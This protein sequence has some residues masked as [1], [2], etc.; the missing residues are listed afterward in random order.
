MRKEEN[1][2][3][4]ENCAF[5]AYLPPTN[6]FSTILYFH[7]GGFESGDKAD[8][9]Q[10]ELAKSFARLG[11]GFISANYRMYPSGARFPDFLED[12][13]DAVA[14][15]KKNYCDKLGNGKL[16]LFGQS[17]GAWLATMLCVDKQYLAK[18]GVDGEKIDGWLIDSAQM[19]SHFN[20]LKIEGEGNPWAQRIDK[21][22]PIYYVN[23][24]TKFT[25]MF[26][27]FYEKDMPCRPEQNMLFYKAVLHF[28]PKADIE[29]MQLAGTHC[30]G[31]SIKDDD[32]EF[33]FVKAALP[34][35]KKREGV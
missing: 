23:E 5:D 17:A 12:G 11:Y 14:F 35:L 3:Y 32:G 21:F 1:V 31:T 29:Y 26:L 8:E 25:S 28:N 33:A 18:V 6:G 4:N 15:V 19:T 13:A 24:G 9:T 7:G 10:V 30:R 27:T 16:Y 34:W 2:F 20:M 22:A